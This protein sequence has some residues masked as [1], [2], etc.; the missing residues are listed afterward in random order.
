MRQDGCIDPSL[1]S[2]YALF[3]GTSSPW[4]VTKVN[5]ELELSRVVIDVSHDSKKLL[6]PDCA[7]PSSQRD[8]APLRESDALK[9]PK[10]LKLQITLEHST[11]QLVRFLFCPDG[12]L[13]RTTPTSLA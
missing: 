6:C 9:I 7:K 2:H 12:Y 10:N 13:D 8:L 11:Q 3:L 1:N 4:K 5:L